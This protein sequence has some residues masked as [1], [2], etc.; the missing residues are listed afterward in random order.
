MNKFIQLPL[1]LIALLSATQNVKAT[2][3]FYDTTFGDTLQGFT[4]L[5]TT[6]ESS[7]TAIGLKASGKYMGCGAVGNNILVGQLTAVGNLDIFTWNVPNGFVNIP[8][9][10][11]ASCNAVLVQPSDQKTVLIGPTRDS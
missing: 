9:Q 7:V 8:L 4:S 10:D 5:P 2:P 6:Q 1:L 11:F 3:V